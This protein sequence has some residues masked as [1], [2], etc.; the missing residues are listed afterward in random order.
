MTS[1]EI[2]NFVITDDGG[3]LTEYLSLEV[4]QRNY[5]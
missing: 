2:N 4:W 3:G 1:N 5:Q